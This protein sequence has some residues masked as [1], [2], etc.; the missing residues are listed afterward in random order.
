MKAVRKNEIE[1]RYSII[2]T[3]GVR[4]VYFCLIF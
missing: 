1:S 2:T 3:R 4:E